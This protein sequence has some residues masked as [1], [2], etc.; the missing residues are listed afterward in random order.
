NQDTFDFLVLNRQDPVIGALAKEAKS[1]VVYFQETGDMNP[2]QAA[3]LA[4]GSILG[5]G[6][7]LVFKVFSEFKG[8]EHRLEKVAEINK[9]K[10]INDSKATTA[11]S[12]LWALK[13]ISC[14]VILIAGGRHKGID[15]RVILDAAK[16]KVK[17][18]ILIGEARQIIKDALAG[19]LPVEEAD[20]LQE[21]VNKAF[22]SALPGDCVLLSPMCSSFDM[23][24]D[25]ED[26]GRIF[27][28]IVND[29]AKAIS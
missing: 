1:K 6:K 16:L 7:E 22:K 15:Y 20:S 14:P 26:R 8:V 12:A 29:L 23:F 4:V 3:V 25:Y 19:A 10:F 13:N 21:A 18:A 9:V 5:I 28:K 2:N 27:K 11:E 24:T 17:K